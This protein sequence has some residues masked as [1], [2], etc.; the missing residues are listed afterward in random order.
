MQ[1]TTV[2]CI[3]Y[4]VHICAIYQLLFMLD[5]LFMRKYVH[6]MHGSEEYKI[7]MIFFLIHAKI[8]AHFLIL[9]LLQLCLSVITL[10]SFDPLSQRAATNV[11][12]NSFCIKKT[13]NWST[14]P[15]PSK[16][17]FTHLYIIIL[18][19]FALRLSKQ[20]AFVTPEF[21]SP[22]NHNVNLFHWLI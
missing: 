22:V 7:K 5:S 4:A 10:A 20:I 6:I 1:T 13:E 18:H 9:V 19:R 11:D 15:P 14:P 17:G 21:P 12:Q 8:F 2:Y 16:V 3:L